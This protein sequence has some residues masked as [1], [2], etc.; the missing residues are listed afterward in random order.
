M[1]LTIDEIRAKN[2]L[3]L[4]G[5]SSLNKGEYALS[6]GCDPSYISQV[7]SKKTKRNMGNEVARQIEIALGKKKGW[8]DVPQW[9]DYVD[10]GFIPV[11]ADDEETDE[12]VFVDCSMLTVQAGVVG[13][14]VDREEEE[15]KPIAFRR[16]WMNSKGFN[17]T[18]IFACKVRGDSMEP[19]LFAGDTVLINTDNSLPEDGEVSVVNYEGEVMIKR[20]KREA[21]RWYLQSDNADKTRHPD[22]LCDGDYCII[23][24]RVVLKQSSKI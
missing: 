11:I 19:G 9:N 1:E 20:F 15:C 2:Y 12:I 18:K 17:K 10:Q 16:D 22:K 6:L 4:R 7:L 5:K 23:I 8:M 13:F 24:G 3:F 14:V 21:G